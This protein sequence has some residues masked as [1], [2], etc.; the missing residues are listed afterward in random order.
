MDGVFVDEIKRIEEQLESEKSGRP[1]EDKGD[2]DGS[3]EETLAPEGTE[4]KDLPSRLTTE[5]M[6]DLESQGVKH[7]DKDDA[8]IKINKWLKFA[9]TTVREK[10]VL[11]VEQ[12]SETAFANALKDIRIVSPDTLGTK[13]VLYDVKQAGESA[14][15]PAYRAPPLRKAHLR[16][17]VGGLLDAQIQKAIIPSCDVFLL[18]LAGRPGNEHDALAAFLDQDWWVAMVRR[19]RMGLS[20]PAS[21]VGRLGSHRAPAPFQD[22]RRTGSS[23]RRRFARSSSCTRRP[24][25]LRGGTGR[26]AILT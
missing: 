2:G 25:W 18:T 8:T 21:D 13:L 19:A 12:S 5:L 1:D 3:S 11:V 24:V 15:R 23:C 6:K 7:Q 20:C 17:L 4:P 14:S 16:K 26:G 9:D 10:V 22:Y